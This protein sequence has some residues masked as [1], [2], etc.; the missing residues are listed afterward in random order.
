MRGRI[1][2]AG[3]FSCVFLLSLLICMIITGVYINNK[4]KMEYAQMEQLVLSNSNRVNNVL[5]SLL[6]K[7]QVLRT[8][9]VQNDGDIQNFERV[10]ATLMDNASIRNL[11][12]APQGVV[13]S[14]YPLAE[15]EKA[16]GL[17]YFAS[18]AGNAEAVKAKESGKLVLGGPFALVQGGQALVGR[19]PVYLR[20]GQS[21]EDFW[22]IVSI[23]LNYPEALAGAELEQL[24]SQGF[25]FE[26]WR[27]NPDDGQRQVIASS[28]YDYDKDSCYVEKPLNIMNAEWY[29]R[30][31]PIRLWYQYPET[32]I[33]TLMGLIISWLIAS[34]VVH[35]KELLCM[36]SEL[37][38][39]SYVDALTGVLN[40]RG[41]FCE[42]EGLVGAANGKF[43]L[44]YLDL[45]KF[46]KVNDEFGH[47]A[48]DKVL[49][50]FAKVF[51]RQA[52]ERHIFS[53]IGG[54]EFIIVFAGTDD[55]ADTAQFFARVDEELQ[56]PV[57]L[58]GQRDFVITYSKGMAVYPRDAAEI[59]DL[60]SRAD[61]EM[62]KQKR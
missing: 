38:K 21:E 23:T 32:W 46:K 11:I 14:V 54:D 24:Q 4:N 16:L 20:S 34:L 27:I 44:C 1:K 9:V 53:R 61:A 33:F 15:N 49:R 2:W 17:D 7:T 55:P 39:L 37:E 56:K 59:D 62:Y 43:I 5:S 8:L 48:G 12:L 22:G 42:M 35:N 13:K 10:A 36:K 45:N 58:G 51:L 31:S 25:A 26:I 41:L 40:R 3:E 60:L 18:G 50:H 29:F 28:N 6:Y 47:A 52:G 30:I 19:L 57:A